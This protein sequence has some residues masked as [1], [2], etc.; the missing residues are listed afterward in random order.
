MISGKDRMVSSPLEA[1]ELAERMESESKSEDSEQI[2]VD[3]TTTKDTN[4]SPI[5]NLCL[6]D[7]YLQICTIRIGT[8]W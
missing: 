6:K 7:F 2:P 8:L 3:T 5:Q 4:L 1:L